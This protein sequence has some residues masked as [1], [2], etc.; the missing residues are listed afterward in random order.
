MLHELRTWPKQYRA[1]VDGQKMHEVRT[2][3]DREFSVGD[4]LLLR[5]WNPDVEKY[6]GRSQRVLVTHITAG[7]TFGLPKDLCVMSILRFGKGVS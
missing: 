2:T 6:T 4:T 7:G 3:I 1:V 5:E